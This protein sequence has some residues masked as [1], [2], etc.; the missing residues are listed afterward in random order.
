MQTNG[1]YSRYLLRLINF[2]CPI[3]GNNSKATPGLEALYKSVD[4][5]PVDLQFFGL[6]DPDP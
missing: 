1:V 4:Q 5:D 3:T 6:Q 2:L